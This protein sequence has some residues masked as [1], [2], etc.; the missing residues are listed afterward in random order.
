MKLK[1]TKN[2]TV[3]EDGILADEGN[4]ILVNSVEAEKLISAGIAEP[5]VSDV[6][7]KQNRSGRKKQRGETSADTE[8]IN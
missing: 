2:C 5:V 8:T 6:P 1:I 7:A 4:V 3:S